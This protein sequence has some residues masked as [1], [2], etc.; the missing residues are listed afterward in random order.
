VEG[1]VKVYVSLPLTGP[2]GFDGRDAANGARLALEQAG[3]KAGDLEVEAEFLDDA[4]GK[5]WDPVAVGANARMATQDSSAVAYI[6]ELDSQP[7]RM[8]MPITNEASLVQVS[9]TAGAVD[10]TGPAE[11]YPDSP[12]RYRPSGQASFARIVPGDDVL[13]RAAAAWAAEMGVRTVSAVS[14]GSP[15]EDLMVAEFTEAATEAG[16]QVPEEAAAAELSFRAGPEAMRLE[17]PGVAYEVLAQVQAIDPSF[18]EEHL[19][20]FRGPTGPS[21][22][23]GYEAMRLVL[24]AIED[25]DTSADGFREEVRDGV[26][27]ARIEDSL[28]GPFSI[29]D[30]GD[31]TLC[32]VQRWRVEGIRLSPEGAPCPP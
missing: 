10:L 21:S 9:P 23:Y 4:N 26:L 27:G 25:A 16:V 6:G 15:Y 30:E 14:D 22:A 12:D 20:R 11:G 3:G 1:P 32:K 19:E 5:A 7:T 2:R 24:R 13:A 8:S 17:G 18:N 29:T 28:L 31:S